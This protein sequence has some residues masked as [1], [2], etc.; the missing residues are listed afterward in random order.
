MFRVDH[1][2]HF[3]GGC[4]KYND[5]IGSGSSFFKE[6]IW[7]IIINIKIE[8]QTTVNNECC[9]NEYCNQLRA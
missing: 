7:T 4:N 9:S 5:F 2:L 8:F 3:T 1:I 6:N